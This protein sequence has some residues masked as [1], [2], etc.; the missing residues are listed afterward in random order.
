M[1]KR[2]FSRHKK[3]LPSMSENYDVLPR[4]HNRSQFT[5]LVESFKVNNVGCDALTP[6][7]LE[8]KFTRFS[9]QNKLAVGLNSHLISHCSPERLQQLLRVGNYDAMIKSGIKKIEKE[10]VNFS[11][12]KEKDIVGSLFVDRGCFILVRAVKRRVGLNRRWVFDLYLAS[13]HFA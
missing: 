5:K 11:W 7:M 9:E 10:D 3:A 12:H 1:I 6:Q 2:F 4:E 13:R 8:H